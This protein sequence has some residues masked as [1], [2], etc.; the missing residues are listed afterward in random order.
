MQNVNSIF[1]SSALF[2]WWFSNKSGFQAE[3]RITKSMERLH[4]ILSAIIVVLQIIITNSNLLSTGNAKFAQEFYNVLS[5]SQK[6][7]TN[8]VYSP[9]S[10]SA[11]LGLLAIGA[12]G[13]TLTEI[14]NVMHFPKEESDLLEGFKKLRSLLQNKSSSTIFNLASGLF[15]NI[16]F[17]LRQEYLAKSRTTF[18]A[19]LQ[20]LNYTDSETSAKTINNFVEQVTN[21]AIKEIVSSSDLTS[22]TALNLINALYFKSAW[23]Y[24]FSTRKITLPFY[25][26][27]NEDI[28]IDM[29]FNEE[30]NIPYADIKELDA[31]VVALPY[32]DEKFSMLLILPNQKDGIT[33]LEEKLH[34]VDLGQLHTRLIQA[35]VLVLI[36]KF[37]IDST[38]DLKNPLQAVSHNYLLFLNGI[39]ILTTKHTTWQ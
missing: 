13:D 30:I 7:N 9:F 15:P 16:G 11:C 35:N 20:Q 2:I 31:Q 5:A 29:M 25:L 14:Q 12:N 26:P 22:E 10:L 37:K 34:L 39:I 6:N 27:S 33:D 21:H 24:K 38:I 18:Q 4:I 28:E 36:P 19:K 1:F 3:I 8:F 17:D 23:K 32:K